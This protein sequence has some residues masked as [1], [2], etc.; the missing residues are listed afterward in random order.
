MYKC[1]FGTLTKNYLKVGLRNKHSMTH[2]TGSDLSDII[3]NK[4][5]ENRE[6]H[7]LF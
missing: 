1:E 3:I 2:R 7:E 5:R 6:T 4:K